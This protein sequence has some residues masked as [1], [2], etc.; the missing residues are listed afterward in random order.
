[1]ESDIKI[2]VESLT[3]PE[4]QVDNSGSNLSELTP[5]CVRVC[6]NQTCLKQGS[7]KVLQAFQDAEISEVIIEASGCMG[8]CSVGPTVKVTPD[9]TWY[10]RVQPQ[11]VA[12]IIEQHLK[13]GQPVEEKLNPRIHPRFY[14]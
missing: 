3:M 13:G 8:Q 12:I 4:I 5:R 6:Q 2:H 1:M 9:E 14:Y 7:Q 10:Y 11:D